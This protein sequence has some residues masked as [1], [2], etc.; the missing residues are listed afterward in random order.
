LNGTAPGV[1][2]DTEQLTREDLKYSVKIFVRS[3]DANV[4]K[5]TI[6]SSSLVNFHF[7]Q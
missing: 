4:L 2:I 1:P 3:L 7:H 6:D 5:Q